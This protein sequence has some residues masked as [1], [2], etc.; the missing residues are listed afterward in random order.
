MIRKQDLIP[1]EVLD[2]L[3]DGFIRE[4]AVRYSPAIADTLVRDLRAAL[5]E[6]VREGERA[7][8]MMERVSTILVDEAP[9]RLERIVRTEVLGAMNAG[10]VEGYKLAGARKEWL[11]ARDD[12]V[13]GEEP[14]DKFSHVEADGQIKEADEPFE[15][16]GE[17][18]MFPG[19]PSGSAGNIVN[20]R[21]TVLPVIEEE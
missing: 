1:E 18:L 2:E 12:A 9:F 13:R 5:V 16:G 20:C 4:R 17:E 11:T 7:R 19:D 10:S 21:C 15:V 6:G 3:T 8:D 14:D